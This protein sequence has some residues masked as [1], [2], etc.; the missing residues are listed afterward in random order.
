MQ[1]LLGIPVQ[2][3]LAQSTSQTL[4]FEN[5]KQIQ[6][7]CLSPDGALLLSIDCD[8]RALLINRKCV[9]LRFDSHAAQ[10]TVALSH[11]H[12]VQ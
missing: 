11:G 9:L 4:P 10:H 6:T 5:L 2:V 3:N 8:G 7:L 1:A 12:R